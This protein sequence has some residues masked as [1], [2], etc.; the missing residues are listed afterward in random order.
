MTAL[1]QTQGWLQIGFYLVVLLLLAKPLGA[2]MAA[3]YEGR[4]SRAQ[5]LGGWLERTIYRGAGVDATKDMGWI[6]YAMA[7]LWF[8]L[9]GALAVYAAWLPAAH[10][11]PPPLDP[12]PRSGG[13]QGFV[14]W[15]L[16]PGRPR[17]AV[18]STR[19]APEFCSWSCARTTPSKYVGS[20][21]VSGFAAKTQ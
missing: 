17:A 5:R 3:V 8:N 12:R 2:Y 19:A 10:R 7:M 1:F 18:R 21:P 15:P 6:E 13:Y 20:H 16:P 4:A 14:A 9:L 11:A